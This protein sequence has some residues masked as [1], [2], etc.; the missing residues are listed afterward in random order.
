MTM[1]AEGHIFMLIADVS[2]EWEELEAVDG[3]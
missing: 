2:I 1:W 3:A